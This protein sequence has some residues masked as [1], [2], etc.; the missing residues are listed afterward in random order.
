MEGVAGD[1]ERSH[2]CVGH[3]D[4]LGIGVGVEFASDLQSSFRG[5]CSDQLD[6]GQTAG[7]WF[8]A[9]ILADVT[10]QAVLD[11]VPFRRAWRIVAHREGQSARV[12]KF[13]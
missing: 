4:T 11:L 13:L 5:R 9:P 12:G 6:H 1:V 2:F 10:E 3:L 8:S 7:Q